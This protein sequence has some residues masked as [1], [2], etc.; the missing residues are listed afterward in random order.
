MAEIYRVLSER[1]QLLISLPSMWGEHEVPYD[2]RRWTSYG[3][4]KLAI[5]SGFAIVSAEK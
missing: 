5:E 4:E 2:F 1:G 3:A